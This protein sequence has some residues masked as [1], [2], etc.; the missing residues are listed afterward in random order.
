MSVVVDCLDRKESKG[1]QDWLSSE[2]SVGPVLIYSPWCGVCFLFPWQE[3]FIQSIPQRGHLNAEGFLLHWYHCLTIPWW[4]HLVGH[5][6]F[7]LTYSMLF[8]FNF[9]YLQWD[10]IHLKMN[11][12]VAF[13]T[14]TVIRSCCL[15]LV[16]KHFRHP[17]RKPWTVTSIPSFC[18]PG[19]H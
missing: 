2:P 15:Y 8:L 10:E 9:I 18:S 1:S 13:S 19:N 17:K 12:S 7:G 11:N 4:S 5:W 14:F 3:S 16:L 6:G